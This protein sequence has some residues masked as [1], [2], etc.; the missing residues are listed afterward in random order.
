VGFCK[1]SKPR[2]FQELFYLGKFH[3]IDLWFTY[4]VYGVQSTSLRHSETTRTVELTICGPDLIS[5]RVMF[6]SNRGHLIKDGWMGF[7]EMVI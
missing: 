2:D 7:Y 4:R 1:I 5:R 6:Q 3:G